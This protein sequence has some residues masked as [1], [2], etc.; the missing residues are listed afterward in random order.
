ME[1]LNIHRSDV[2]GEA[3]QD[4]PRAQVGTWLFLSIFCA[5]QE[6]G[7]RIAGAK[8]WS[9]RKWLKVTSLSAEE[10]QEESGLWHWDGEDLVVEFYPADQEAVVRSKRRGGR[11]GGKKRVENFRKRKADLEGVPEGVL[12]GK[13]KADLEGVVEGD[14]ERKGREGKEKERNEREE[15][16][17]GDESLIPTLS[18]VR[19]WAEMS[20]VDPE[21]AAQKHAATSETHGWVKN[22]RLIDWRGRFKRYWDEDRE[23]WS[24][25]NK[26]TAAVNG[27]SLPTDQD[28][29]WTE[30][31][32]LVKKALVG[33]MMAGDEAKG[34]RLKEVL[35]E[36]GCA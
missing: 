9:D 11:A 2:E 31:V 30:E 34:A 24:R 18:E 32:D 28:W 26:K 7:G 33:A 14:L 8:G 35:K 10:V 29:W 21:F 6:N 5:G 20:A 23:G 25:K 22:G 17:P 1:W 3:M 12:E 13:A 36:R 4:A 19:T 16:A 27:A 15:P